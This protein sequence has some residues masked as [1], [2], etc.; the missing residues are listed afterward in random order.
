MKRLLDA[1]MFRRAE[2]LVRR[3]RP[4]LPGSGRLLDVGSGTGHNALVLERR[5][6]LAVTEID[7]APMNCVGRTPLLFDGARL[8]FADAAF[9]AATLL[10]VLHYAVD[11]ALLLR[12]ARRVTRGPLLVLQ[13]VSASRTGA[14]LLRA[15]EWGQGR[16]AYRAT[17]WAGLLPRGPHSLTPR[18]FHTRPSLDRL[19]AAAGLRVV[20]REPS[21][22]GWP[23]LSRELLG[24]ERDEHG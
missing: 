12:E 19:V 14:A 10:F 4:H 5:T 1:L 11:P 15:R 6:G 2:Q 21:V 9:E 7:V 23:G 16:G 20:V 22:D 24:L 17:Q 8:P 3:L 18:C 13:S